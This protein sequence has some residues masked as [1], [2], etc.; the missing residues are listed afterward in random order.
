MTAWPDLTLFYT[1]NIRGDLNALPR[2]QTFIR[3]LMRDVSG[4]KLLLDLGRSCAPDVWPCG[5]TE[6]RSTLLVLDAM[7][8]YAANIQGM[9]TPA[10]REK[11][12]GQVMLHLIDDDHPH[13]DEDITFTTQATIDAA[14]CLVLTPAQETQLQGNTLYL[15]EVTHKQV[16]VV[17][18][19]ASELSHSIHTLPDDVKPEPTI[20]GAVD[21]VTGE[22]RY[23]EKRQNDGDK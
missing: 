6:G 23:F 3:S 15:A 5:V 21:F 19:K 18:L 2:M 8:Y 12:A 22:A 9:L 13:K 17:R 20:S 16:G 1:A 14:F 11:L 7:G 4:R 10:S